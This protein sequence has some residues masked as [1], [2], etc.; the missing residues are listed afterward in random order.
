MRH[1]LPIIRAGINLPTV[2]T[3][4]SGGLLFKGEVALVNS[5]AYIRGAY[6][7]GGSYSGFYGM[8]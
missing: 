8:L 6:I 2:G 1:T 3:Q 4:L 5:R 7:L